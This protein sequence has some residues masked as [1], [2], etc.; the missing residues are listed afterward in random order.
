MNAELLATA[1]EKHRV[2]VHKTR[3]SWVVF[4][5]CEQHYTT[6]HE[7]RLNAMATE[8]VERFVHLFTLQVVE[9]MHS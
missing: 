7:K 8:Q 3:D 2:K 9:E 1:A 6:I 5:P 4:T